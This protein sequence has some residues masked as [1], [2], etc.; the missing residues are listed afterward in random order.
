MVGDPLPSLYREYQRQ[1][2]KIA[3]IRYASAV[4]QWDQETYLP[5]RGANM[6]GQQIATLS[7]IAHHFF[8]SEELGSLLQEIL[9]KEGLDAVQKRVINLGLGSNHL[10]E[11]L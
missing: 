3:D 4:L 2:N 11:I 5:P 9:G 10:H 1:M 8:T 7:E 6:R